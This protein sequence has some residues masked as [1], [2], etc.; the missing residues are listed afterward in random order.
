MLSSDQSE[1]L[2]DAIMDAIFNDIS[3]K[4]AVEKIKASVVPRPIEE[5]KWKDFIAHV[6]RLELWPIRELFGEELS[7]WMADLQIGSGGWPTARVLLKPLTYSGAVTELAARSGFSIMGP[8]M[9][10]RMRDLL[11][12]K[13]K[14][15]RAD[16]Q[17]RETLMRQQ[18][19][20]GLGLDARQADVA[21][22]VLNEI[23]QTVEIL[24]ENEYADWLA[25][26][27]KKK[28]ESSESGV[29]S[30][31]DADDEDISAMKL[32]MGTMPNQAQTLLD[33]A[34]E[35][36]MQSITNKPTDDYLLRRLRSVVSSR[37]R[38]V[39]SSADARQIL[40]RDSKVGGVG[41]TATDADLVIEQIELAY[42][43]SHAS[44]RE[45]E[46]KKLDEQMILQHQKIEERKRRES[47]EH[48]KWFQE[49][50]QAKKQQEEQ[51]EKVTQQMRQIFAAR[52]PMSSAPT[53]AK[54]KVVEQ[55]RFGEMVSA[56][57][58]GAAPI[59]AP[60]NQFSGGAVNMPVSSGAVQAAR[61]EIRVSKA[62]A[63]M[64]TQPTPIAK[65][66]MDDVKVAA[67]SASSFGGDGPKLVGLTG[68][69]SALSLTEFRRMAQTPDIAAQKIL[70]KIETL[71]Q[72]SFEK[73]VAGVR[74]FQASPLQGVYMALVAESFK[75][76]K[77][78]AQ[79]ADEK[80]AQG[81]S[82]VSS[83][84]IAAILTLNSKL[85]F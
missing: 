23:L 50:V 18:D 12:S 30:P 49:K 42:Q 6:I 24:S 20:G 11:V 67:P 74:A 40:L 43:G 68:E 60:V 35:Q 45:D 81:Q 7:F 63:T 75:T 53:D 65:A 85:H 70:E 25:E 15:V 52:V 8:Q 57:D 41:M 71:G 34:V 33:T 73:R 78:V 22:S 56:T 84:E 19:F 46:K 58:K 31:G 2:G 36:A 44:I 47:E 64:Q 77:P 29:G 76:G 9:R 3:L 51:K 59:I 82:G 62:T 55:K 26:Q 4:E 10:E 32:K 69:L 21:V 38:D 83:I 1:V 39:R 79:L 66:K 37:L 80:R 13:L 72:E 61:P 17:I 48:A 28:E 5:A 16:A 54:A 27:S 14:G